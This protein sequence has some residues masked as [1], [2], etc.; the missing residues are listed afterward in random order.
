MVGATGAVGSQLVEL[1][2]ARGFQ[3]RELKLFAGEKGAIANARSRTARSG[4][5]SRWTNPADLRGFDI[6]FLAIPGSARRRDY[7]RAR[8]RVRC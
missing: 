1:I 2:A 3:L 5:S 4:W 6:A 7:H 8:G